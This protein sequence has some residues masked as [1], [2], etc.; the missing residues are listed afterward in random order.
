[1][2]VLQNHS[3]KWNNP[4]C[5]SLLVQGI[6]VQAQHT[7]HSGHNIYEDINKKKKKEAKSTKV[8]EMKYLM[9]GGILV[10]AV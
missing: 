7:S 2:L 9:G 8:I 4:L 5:L 3:W 6:F 10:E 1:M